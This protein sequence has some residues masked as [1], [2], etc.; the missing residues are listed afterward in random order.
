MP[1]G[2]HAFDHFCNER[3]IIHYLIDPGKLAQNGAVK[4]SHREGQ[5]KFYE[6]NMFRSV[7][8]LQRKMQ[9]WNTYYNNLE[10]CG[11]DGKTPNEFLDE[12]A[13]VNLPNVST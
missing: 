8:D 2:I 11:L 10:H 5:E 6:T 1:K 9:T 4:R 3:N 12:Y 7:H 13:K